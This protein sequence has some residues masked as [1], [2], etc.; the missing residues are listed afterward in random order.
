MILD[1]KPWYIDYQG[2]RLGAP[3]Y[4]IASLTYDAKAFIPAAIRKKTID[5]HLD[6]LLKPL[7]SQGSHSNSTRG[8]SPSSG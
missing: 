6:L 5:R 8:L 4:D 1:G 3:Q 7:E 2:G